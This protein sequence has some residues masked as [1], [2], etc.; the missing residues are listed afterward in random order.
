[1]ET[2]FD[3]TNHILVPEHIKLPDADKE[4]I[5]K[6]YNISQNQLP[7]ILLTDPAIQHLIPK[8]GDVIRI[9]RPSPTVGE[10][11]FYRVIVH[12]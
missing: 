10:T 8:I 1:M 9:K 6:Q 11:F 2:P 4:K 5:L 3:I 7:Q 12:G